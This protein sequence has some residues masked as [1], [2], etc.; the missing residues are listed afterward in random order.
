MDGTEYV[1]CDDGPK[2]VV[3]APVDKHKDMCTAVMRFQKGDSYATASRDGTIRVWA[4]D[5]SKG[6]IMTHRKT[7]KTGGAYIVDAA[8][9]PASQRMLI[10]CADRKVKVYDPK[11]WVIVGT[12][13]GLPD[14]PVCAAAW[15]GGTRIVNNQDCEYVS[16]HTRA[17]LGRSTGR[18]LTKKNCLSPAPLPHPGDALDTIPTI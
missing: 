8:Q 7:A 10:A 6:G 18:P 3:G 17:A 2:G 16:L 4:H 14:A 5:D 9:L 12:Y 11:G 1:L 13:G 15:E